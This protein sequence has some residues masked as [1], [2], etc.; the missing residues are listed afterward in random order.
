MKNNPAFKYFLISIFALIVMYIFIELVNYGYER[1]T[2]FTVE[3]NSDHDKMMF[4]DDFQL[5]SK[6]FFDFRNAKLKVFRKGTNFKELIDSTEVGYSRKD[7]DIV[8]KAHQYDPVCL[9]KFGKPIL[10]NSEWKIMLTNGKEFKITDIDFKFINSGSKG[11]CILKSYK[12]NDLKYIYK[13]N[14]YYF[15]Q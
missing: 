14:M 1:L 6:D 2:R 13:N 8:V 4:D 12:I 15:I 9:L 10:V 11:Y 3:P 5:E 7:F